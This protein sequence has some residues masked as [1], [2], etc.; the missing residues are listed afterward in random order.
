MTPTD[1]LGN[2]IPTP[3]SVLQTICNY[4]LPEPISVITSL[5]LH[6]EVLQINQIDYAVLMHAQGI[7]A[8]LKNIYIYIVWD[9]VVISVILQKKFLKGYS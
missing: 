8:L 2:T 6:M 4:S 9:T 1:S 7:N 3:V 5:L